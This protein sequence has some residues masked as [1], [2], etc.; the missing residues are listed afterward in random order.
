MFFHSQ[1]ADCACASLIIRAPLG[2][3]KEKALERAQKRDYNARRLVARRLAYRNDPP[4]EN[5]W[6][7]CKTPLLT[8]PARLNR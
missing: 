8:G 7:L 3:I 2:G 4:V 5:V 1:R 6:K